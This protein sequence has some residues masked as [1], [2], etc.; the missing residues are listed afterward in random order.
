MSYATLVDTTKCVGCRSC[1][2]S[3]KQW[4][5]LPA[6][7]TQAAA[8]PGLQQPASVSAKTRTVV[9]FNEVPND[10]KPGGLD[11]VFVKRQCMHCKEP[12]CVSAC[13]VTAMHKTETGAV[14]YDYDK[15]IGCRYCVWA[16]P[17][18][19]PAVE[20]DTLAPKVNKCD[21][22]FGRAAE[23]APTARNGQALD[24]KGS[25]G[26]LAK[27]ASPAC[28]GQCPPG[29]LEFG[30]R[31]E[32]LERARKRIAA[33][34]G[35]YVDHIYGEK[36]AGG[37][38]WLYL[39]AVP[40][41]KLGFPDVGNESYPARSSVALGSVPPAVSAVGVALGAAYA[42]QQRKERVAAEKHGCGGGG[43]CGGCGPSSGGGCG[44]VKA[45][46]GAVALGV[47]SPAL[48]AD[49]AK[50]DAVDTG[51]HAVQH[52]HGHD[53]AHGHGAPHVEFAPLKAPLW[54]GFNKAMLALVFGGVVSLVARFALGLG[55][56]TGLSDTYAWGLWIIFDLVWIAL[57]AGAFATAG[58]I[59][60]FRQDH[61]YGVG[62]AA[63][64]LGFLSYSFVAVTLLA[65]LGLPWHFYELGLNIPE[66]SAMYEVSWCV[67][68]YVT[69]LALEFAPVA[70]DHF[71]LK[72]GREVWSKLVP[73]WVTLAVTLFTFL[74]S[75]SLVWTGL[76]FAVFATM[77]YLYRPKPGEKTTPLLPAMAAVT[78]SCMHQSSLGS[79]FLLMPDKLHKLWWAPTLPVHFLVSAIAAGCA[80]TVLVE[81][82]V[83]KAFARRIRMEQVASLGKVVGWALLAAWAIRLTDQ[84][85]RGQLGAAFEGGIAN[86]FLAELVLGGLLPLAL[87]LPRATRERLPL[88]V[89]GVALTAAGVVVHRWAV[90]MGA[91]DLKGPMPAY[92]PQPAYSASIVEWGI[93][94][95]LI[96]ATVFLF[97]LGIRKL[98]VLPVDA[99]AASEGKV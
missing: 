10:A 44:D 47:Q 3:C 43:G 48:P 95:G 5:G 60:V 33:N 11:Y 66:H 9:T 6:E 56:T 21:M 78:F 15:C 32:L 89:T 86:L 67:S 34:P 26:F 84:G 23:A 70:L 22:C 62:R 25:E 72:K 58:I 2:V 80:L 63:V 8:A 7:K 94:I 82:W 50:E 99:P 16:C 88:L 38:G 17:F 41:E 18:G 12:A 51:P 96:A 53:G 68:L 40:F 59:Y 75:R 27:H 30:D 79:L 19:A 49:L 14:V 93:S 69:I 83:A 42:F 65:D 54:T 4:N 87:L 28:V 57:A 39:S 74:M 98:P 64:L 81:L 85:V 45:A 1:Q 13:P 36:E 73:V 90:V 29:A 37:T 46:A 20:W 92:S 76:A 77:A 55:A 61:L 71:G 35:K 52:G 31:E 97:N 91:M 24:A